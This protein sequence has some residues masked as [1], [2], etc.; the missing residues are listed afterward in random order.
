V[1]QAKCINV[2][3]NKLLFEFSVIEKA[4]LVVKC[5]CGI[6]NHFNNGKQEYAKS[7]SLLDSYQDRLTINK[8]NG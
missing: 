6:H 4:N 2:K 7:R 3:C 5:K 1:K 8:K